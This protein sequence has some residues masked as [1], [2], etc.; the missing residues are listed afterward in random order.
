METQDR[1]VLITGASRGLGR[2]LAFAFAEAGA[3]EVFAGARRPEDIEKLKSDAQALGAAIT[4]V[5]LDVTIDSDVEAAADLGRGPSAGDPFEGPPKRRT[6]PPALPTP[7][8]LTRHPSERS[9]LV[10]SLGEAAARLGVSRATL[11]AMIEA[12][13]V[14]ALPTGFTRTILTSEVQRAEKAP[15]EKSRWLWTGLRCQHKR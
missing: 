15:A 6:P 11:E 12:G 13:K 2:T 3:R 8:A 7:V 10:L 14:D 5:K 1:T 4:P 9:E